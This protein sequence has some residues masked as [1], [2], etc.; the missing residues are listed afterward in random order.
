MCQ[1]LFRIPIPFIGS[2]AIYGF[3]LML[4]VGW[5]AGTWVGSWRARREGLKVDI[6]DLGFWMLIGGIV[7]ARLFYVVQH[8]QR[9]GGLLDFF[10]IW[11]GGL[12]WY[13]GVI[14]AVVTF[15]WQVRRKKLPAWKLCDVLAPAVALGMAFG[16]VGCF[17]NGCCYGDPTDLPWAAHFPQ[18]SIPY[19][20]QVRRG[21]LDAAAN[22]SL[23][24]HPTQLYS[25]VDGLVLFL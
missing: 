23:G 14:G 5:L 1:T 4:V 3:G 17:L 22:Q 16:R 2:V 15:I 21:M 10:K 18:D 12:V 25:A 8:G 7:G 11:E 20:E 19:V 13:G 24:V 6:A 9:F